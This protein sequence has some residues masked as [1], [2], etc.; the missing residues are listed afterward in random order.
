MATINKNPF[1]QVRSRVGDTE[2]SLEW[3][4]TQVK[5]LSKAKTTP[6]NLLRNTPDLVNRVL[7]G[8]MYM[9]FYDAKLKDTL[10]Y[11][12]MFP[13]VLPFRKVPDGF[14]GINLHYLPYPVRFKLLEILH[15]YASDEKIDDNTKV[16]VSWQTLLT[17]SRVAPIKGCVKHYLNSH[18]QSRFL[19]IKYPDWITA[20]LLPVE[21]FIG[22]TKQ[23]VWR[24]TREKN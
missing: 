12:D 17:M 9:F 10:P 14:F 3:Y 1:L 18:I 5:A 7:P 20:S 24:T 8:N 19:S 4:Q 13:M 15:D 11:W 21:Q 2:R 16:R 22:A 6:S 23:E